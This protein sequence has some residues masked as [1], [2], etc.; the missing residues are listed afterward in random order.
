MTAMT[1]VGTVRTYAKLPPDKPFT[2]DTWMEAVQ[3]REYFC[4]LRPT[5]GI[6]GGREAARGSH[7][8]ATQRR[9]SRRRLES[10]Q[11]DGTDEPG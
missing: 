1:A 11:R 6:R 7:H 4:D 9:L 10:G 5:A 2:Y 8:S 3:V